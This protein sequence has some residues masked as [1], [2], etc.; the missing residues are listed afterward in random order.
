M[1]LPTLDKVIEEAELRRTASVSPTVHAKPP[2][3]PVEPKPSVSTP[4]PQARPATPPAEVKPAAAAPEA[5]PAP[6]APTEPARA[7]AGGTAA[8]IKNFARRKA[9]EAYDAGDYATA[10]ASLERVARFGADAE[11]LQMLQDCYTKLN[12]PDEAKRVAAQL[13]E[14]QRVDGNGKLTTPG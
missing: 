13:A 11:T 5:K 6:A 3:P 7:V 1:S 10:V 2:A 8:G 14:L 4:P 9:R 12:Q